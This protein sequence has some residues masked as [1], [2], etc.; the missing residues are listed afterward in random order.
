MAAAAATA[1]GAG[2][3]DGAVVPASVSL[4]LKIRESFYQSDSSVTITL[5]AKNTTEARVAV[6]VTPDAEDAT[7]TRQ[8]E[9]VV[10]C[11]DGSEYRRAWRLWSNVEAAVER[12]LTPYKVELVMRKAV[13]EQWDALE[14]AAGSQGGTDASIIRRGGGG[15][16]SQQQQQNADGSSKSEEQRPSYPT[17]SRNRTNFDELDRQLEAEEEEEKPQGDAAL[18]QLFQTIYAGGDE[19]TKKAMMK[20]FQTSGGTVLST[21]WKEVAEKD[22]EKDGI[23][24]P[25]GM[26]VKKYEY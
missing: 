23:T 15:S 7:R 14:C 20:S 1:G 11:S 4:A 2:G 16:S 26:E 22:Y 5:F 25:A 8:L 19:N 12:R 17:S 3:A 9:V 21:N 24:P 18:Q 6:A 10:T 13:R